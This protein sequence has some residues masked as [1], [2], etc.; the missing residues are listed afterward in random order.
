MISQEQITRLRELYE[1]ATQ[2]SL[3]PYFIGKKFDE[4]RIER[5][6]FAGEYFQEVHKCLPELLE[7]A[8]G[9]LLE[10]ETTHAAIEIDTDHSYPRE[11]FDKR[12]M[13]EVYTAIQKAAKALGE[14]TEE[15][16]QSWDADT[17]LINIKKEQALSHLCPFLSE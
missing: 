15:H 10:F 2:H 6:V 3:E 12:R 16:L 1:K 4:E 14:I 9:Y 8:E 17:E 13:S 5:A 11:V 7:A